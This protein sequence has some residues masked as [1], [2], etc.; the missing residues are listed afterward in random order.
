MNFY[1]AS[2]NLNADITWDEV[3]GAGSIQ[4]P[5]YNDG[6]R[7]CWDEDQDDIECPDTTS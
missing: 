5:D 1:D 3:T 7:A 4:V 6:E 2:E